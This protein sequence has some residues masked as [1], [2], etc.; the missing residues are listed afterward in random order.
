MRRYIILQGLSGT[1]GGFLQIVSLIVYYVKLVLFGSTPR[2]VFG[3]KY[4]ETSVAWGTLFPLTTLISVVGTCSFFCVAPQF[5]QFSDRIYDHLSNCQRP[6]L[7]HLLSL[8]PF[9]QV[10]LPLG[11]PTRNRYRRS[12]L[13][14]GASTLVRRTLRRASM[15][16][17]LVLPFAGLQS[18]SERCSRG[19]FD[20]CV[21]HLHGMSPST[22]PFDNILTIVIV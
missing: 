15:R 22:L 11:I 2:S 20:D 5:T 8:L 14:Q 10:P 21:D 9:I 16:G 12:V 18:E 19:C 6:C 7:R 4:G 3:V 1:A 13:P 17:C